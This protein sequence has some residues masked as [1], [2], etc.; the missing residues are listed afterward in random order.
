MSNHNNKNQISLITDTLYQCFDY[1]NEN[2]FN[3]LLP[4]PIITLQSKGKSRSLGWC[5]VIPIWFNPKKAE[6]EKKEYY[7]INISAEHIADLG[8]VGIIETLL[9]EMVHLSNISQGIKDC[10]PKTQYHNTKFKAECDR[11]GLVCEQTQKHGWSETS[12]SDNLRSEIEELEIDREI[13][14]IQR[15]EN[16]EKKIIKKKGD[17]KYICE[18]CGCSAKA[19]EGVSLICGCCKVEMKCVDSE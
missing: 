3:L 17:L 12:L 6:E 16:V 2:K 10:N 14:C 7:E 5:S 13:F 1:F 11:I 9:H 15:A 19:K 8:Y 4:H 18:G